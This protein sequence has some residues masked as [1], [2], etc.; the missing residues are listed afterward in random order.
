MCVESVRTWKRSGALCLKTGT[1]RDSHWGAERERERERERE[2]MLWIANP[3]RIST[4]SKDLVTGSFVQASRGQWFLLKNKIKRGS[5]V[6]H[7]II[8]SM[9]Q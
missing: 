2:E 8:R 6:G 4:R 5:M 9:G 3:D 1:G 7:W